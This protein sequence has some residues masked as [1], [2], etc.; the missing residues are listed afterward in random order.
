[1]ATAKELGMSKLASLDDLFVHELQEAYDAESQIQRALPTMV[2]AATNRDLKNAFMAHRRETE[3]QIRRLVQVFG[4]LGLPVQRTACEGVTGLL[5]K[6]N[7]LIEWTAEA[8][9]LDAALIA[10]AQKLE[11]YEIATY[12]CLCTYAEMLGYDQAHSL[13][14]QTLDEEENIDMKLTGLAESVINPH[15]V[16]GDSA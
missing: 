6:S 9:V 16:E 4:V 10:T 7:K 12:G 11:H 15:A 3:G 14:G 2:R 1:M 13:L 8:D 5:E